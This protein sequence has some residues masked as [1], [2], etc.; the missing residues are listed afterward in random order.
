[1]A[2]PDTATPATAL[3]GEP[4]LVFEQLPG[5]LN[6]LNNET[7]TDRQATSNRLPVL[8]A[9][10]SAA[11]EGL[12]AAAKTA[13]NQAI[14]I[15]QR[16]TEAKALLKHGEWLPWLNEH[17][18]LSERQAQKYMRIARA[19]EALA[20]KAPLTA[21]LTIERAIEALSVAKPPSYLPPAGFIKIG[22]RKSSTVVVAPSYQHPGFFYVTRFTQNSDGTGDIIGGRRPIRS[23][24]ADAMVIAIDDNFATYDW[25][26][27]PSSAWAFNLLLFDAAGAYVNSLRLDDPEDRAELLDLAETS[28]PVD[29]GVQLKRQVVQGGAA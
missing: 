7:I 15:G 29:F 6:S 19:K 4:A 18:F 27:V 24:F 5:Q 25:R 12:N 16:L 9:E 13:I 21:D 1:M 14:L 2:L 26:D 20:A 23:D 28:D 8:A 10:I 3:C 22:E 11:R 17:C